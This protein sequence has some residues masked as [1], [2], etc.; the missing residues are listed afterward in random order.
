[1]IKRLIF[2]VDGTLIQGGDFIATVTNTLKRLNLYSEENLE[3]Y[4][5]A[6]RTYEDYYNN[7][8]VKDYVEYFS[9][10]LSVKL[11]ENFIAIFFDEVSRCIPE[12][13]SK[14]QDKL[15]ELSKDYEM[16]ILTNYFREGQL[17]RLKNMGIDRYFSKCYGEE[18]IK[19]NKEAYINSCGNNKPEE[20]IMIGDNIKLDIKGAKECGLHTIWINNK[21]TEAENMDTLT[22]KSVSDITQEM[23]DNI[24]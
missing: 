5:N 23:I 11:D 14:L 13:N 17:G 10:E 21:G 1:M 3:K 18:L 15:E 8:N 22:V 24:K 12:D 20:C 6:T 16:V 7:Y 4:L 19:G 9:K 2:D